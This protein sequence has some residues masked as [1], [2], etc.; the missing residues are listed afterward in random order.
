MPRSVF[1]DQEHFSEDDEGQKI[2][3]FR[4]H[5]CSFS[6]DE[7]S[8]RS[9]ESPDYRCV[10]INRDIEI[11]DDGDDIDFETIVGEDF[12]LDL[13]F[14]EIPQPISRYEDDDLWAEEIGKDEDSDLQSSKNAKKSRTNRLLS[15]FKL[16]LTRIHHRWFSKKKSSKQLM[17]FE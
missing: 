9:R 11:F 2:A 1:C 7:S 8:S 16:P 17:V 3:E 10:I 13:L 12:E 14:N 15:R 6:P 4:R 5:T